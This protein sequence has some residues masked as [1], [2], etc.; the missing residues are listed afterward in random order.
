M[1]VKIS[2]HGFIQVYYSGKDTHQKE[3]HEKGS[4]VEDK[5]RSFFFYFYCF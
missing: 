4:G 1:S 2:I 3:E 5:K